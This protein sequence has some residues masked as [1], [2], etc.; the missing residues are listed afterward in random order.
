MRRWLT[1]SSPDQLE[2]TL[3]LDKRHQFLAESRIGKSPIFVIETD[4]CVASF[5]TLRG[6]GVHL[7]DPPVSEPWDVTT[8]FIDLHVKKLQMYQPPNGGI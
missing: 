1:V 7:N 2:L 6:Q 8:R 4:V 3:V 5:E